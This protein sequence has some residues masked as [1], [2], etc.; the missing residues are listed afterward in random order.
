MMTSVDVYR[1]AAMDQLHQPAVTHQLTDYVSQQSNLLI[2]V[3]A[4][5]H[6]KQAMMK[7]LTLIAKITY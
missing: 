2:C 1:A 3:D 4:L 6:A 5:K 7:G